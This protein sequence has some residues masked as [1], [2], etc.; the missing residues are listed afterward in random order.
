ME[1]GAR[2]PK[3]LSFDRKPFVPF[4]RIEYLEDTIRPMVD[5]VY[6]DAIRTVETHFN[7][8]HHIEVFRMTA[9]RLENEA[10]ML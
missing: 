6:A 1:G 5:I 2:R 8:V 10:Q 9:K 3:S 7:S 4:W